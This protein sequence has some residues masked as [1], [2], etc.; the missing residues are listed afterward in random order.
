M[1]GLIGLANA[2]VSVKSRRIRNGDNPKDNQTKANT[3]VASRHYRR[4][5]RP[6]F[7]FDLVYRF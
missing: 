4:R 1:Q 2:L 7:G 6:Y 5:I 3:L